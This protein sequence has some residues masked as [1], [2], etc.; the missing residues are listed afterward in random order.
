MQEDKNQIVSGILR[1]RSE[2]EEVLNELEKLPPVSESSVHFAAHALSNYLTVAGGTVELLQLMLAEHPDPKVRTGLEA[3]QRATS[4]M[5]H[6]VSQLVNAQT[7]QDAEMRFEKVEMPLMAQRFRIYYQRIA[8]QKQIQCL[9]GS[10]VDVPPVWTDRVA[11]AAALDNL[12]SNA[13]KYSPPGKRIWVEVVSQQNGV[14][15]SVRDEGPGLSQED[16]AKL[17]QRGA[18]LTPKP[19]GGEPSAG[20]GLAVAKQL[21]EKVGGTIWCESV[22]GQGACFSFRLPQY[23]EQVHGSE[24]QLPGSPTGVEQGSRTAP[25]A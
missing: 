10:T 3:L 9:A 19:T 24:R 2:L 6:T 4:L 23:Q 25:Y 12:F 5:L 15:C 22:L 11:T 18:Q 1:A 14:V 8:N 7:D 16:Q 21:I 13:V 17:F 20:Y